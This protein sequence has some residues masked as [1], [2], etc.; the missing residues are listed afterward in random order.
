MKKRHAVNW[1]DHRANAGDDRDDCRRIY[2]LGR[3]RRGEFLT[4]MAKRRP[5]HHC[6]CHEACGSCHPGVKFRRSRGSRR[7]QTPHLA[8]I[9]SA[10]RRSRRVERAQ[11]LSP[12]SIA[13]PTAETDEMQTARQPKSV[14]L[15][16]Q[17]SGQTTQNTSPARRPRR[18]AY[19]T[20]KGAG[21][22]PGFSRA[23]QL[24][25]KLGM[26]RPPISEISITT[27]AIPMRMLMSAA[28]WK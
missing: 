13:G 20:G 14:S 25:V 3:C 26:I 27:T 18:R 19:R 7:K 24:R 6:Q 28:P 2:R 10:R 4:G 15:F 5:A 17:P 21:K 16:L 23:S 8:E 11:T 12:G 9:R 22:R 1:F